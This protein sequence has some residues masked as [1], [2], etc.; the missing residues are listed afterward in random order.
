MPDLWPSEFNFSHIITPVAVLREQASLISQ[1]TQQIING[2]TS[3]SKY[4]SQNSK[5]ANFFIHTLYF[6]VP[7]LDDYEYRVLNVRHKLELFP[8]TI[9]SHIHDSE[10]DCPNLE[11]YQNELKKIFGSEEMIQVVSS[12]MAQVKDIHSNT[13]EEVIA[14]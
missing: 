13:S 5:G 6:V 14:N 9:T 11:E 3:T 8:V 7:L 12:L 1:K 10:I 4:Q 2:R